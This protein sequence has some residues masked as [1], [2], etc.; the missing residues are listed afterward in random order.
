MFSFTSTGRIIHRTVR[1]IMSFDNWFLYLLF[2]LYNRKG[3][4]SFS[5]RGLF[6]LSINEA[7]TSRFLDIFLSGRFLHPFDQEI[8]KLREP[9]IL[10]IGAGEGWFSLYILSR[11]PRAKLL[12]F[13]PDKV[14]FG[15]L[16]DRWQAYQ[17]SSFSV[18]NERV[19]R[20]D[21]LHVE[22]RA[23]PDNGLIKSSR[24]PSIRRKQHLRKI[25]LLKLTCGG[26]AYD[27]LYS[28]PAREFLTIERI[29][30]DLPDMDRIAR[31]RKSMI[32]FLSNYGYQIYLQQADHGD[33]PVIRAFRVQKS[34]R[35]SGDLIQNMRDRT[36]T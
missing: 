13:E 2:K 28:L 18:F 30:L 29:V 6:E 23:Y 14:Q 17:H 36:K 33:Q 22:S 31:N 8:K 26:D 21:G 4:F 7:Q 20:N 10:D 1:F 15:L 3:N 24:L 32:D 12:A 11:F 19:W 27:I 16:Q 25:H 35:V 34:T 5:V 9:V